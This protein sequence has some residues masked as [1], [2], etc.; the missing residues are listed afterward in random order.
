MPSPSAILSYQPWPTTL[1]LSDVVALLSRAGF[2][3]EQIHQILHLPSQG[4]AQILVVMLWT[5]MA[6]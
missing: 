2:D 5:W 6:D 3:Q 4:L 1:P